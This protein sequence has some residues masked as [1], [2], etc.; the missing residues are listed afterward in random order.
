[1]SEVSRNDPLENVLESAIE[2]IEGDKV[3]FGDVLEL[4]GD[5]SFGPIV[6]FLGLLV[7]LPPLGAVPILPVIV[8]FVIILFSTQILFGAKHIWVPGFIAKRSISKKQLKEADKRAKP[9]LKRI[10]RLISER[11]RFLTGRWSIYLAAILVT[12]LALTMIPLEVVPFA[13]AAPGVAI[14]LFG[15]AFMARDGVLML[16]GYLASIGAITVTILF[17]PWQMFLGG[18]SGG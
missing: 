13:V 3:T 4:F 18:G 10:D 11:M 6:A 7:V 12:F 9:W 8:G 14:V 16:L 17:V 1:M 2:D 15:L 5:R